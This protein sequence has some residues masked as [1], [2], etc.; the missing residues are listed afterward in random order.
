M[1]AYAR[2]IRGGGPVQQVERVLSRIGVPFCMGR[3]NG[4]SRAHTCVGRRTHFSGGRQ[5]RESAMCTRPVPTAGRARSH[6]H[7][8]S[9]HRLHEDE[10]RQ[11]RCWPKV[12][13]WMM[14]K[15]KIPFSLMSRRRQSFSPFTF[16]RTSA[17]VLMNMLIK[18]TRGENERLTCPASIGSRRRR[19]R[20]WI[21]R[22]TDRQDGQ[23]MMMQT[24]CC[25]TREAVT[26]ARSNGVYNRTPSP[27]SP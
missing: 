14:S 15:K 9:W 25:M 13:H 24:S 23:M 18:W 11:F 21:I 1:C 26:S 5:E 2:R 7:I 16:S 22:A 19:D 17:G 8:D 3:G 27:T 4:E 12:C 6:P 20:E 10:S